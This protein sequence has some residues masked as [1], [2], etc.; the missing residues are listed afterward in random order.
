MLIKTPPHLEYRCESTVNVTLQLT[1]AS[2]WVTRNVI[3]QWYS[4]AQWFRWLLAQSFPKTWSWTG[5]PAL[6]GQRGSFNSSN[7]LEEEWE[8]CCSEVDWGTHTKVHTHTHTHAHWPQHSRGD[9]QCVGVRVRST[10]GA[11]T[12]DMRL[13]LEVIINHLPSETVCAHRAI[14]NTISFR[15]KALS[16]LFHRWDRFPETWTCFS[17]NN[18]SELCKRT[19]QQNKSGFF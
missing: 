6:Q 2:Q 11:N 15:L 4:I 10:H 9:G 8:R 12:V 1:W 18:P 19:Q 7:P 13:T 3:F 16:S 14:I 5:I 17:Q